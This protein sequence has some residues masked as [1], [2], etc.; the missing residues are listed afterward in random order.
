MTTLL[1]KIKAA[2]PKFFSA[3]NR[4]FMEDICF[5]GRR[6]KKGNAFLIEKTY[7]FS[8]MLGEPR[9]ISFR[10]HTV[11]TETFKIEH[12]L[13]TAYPTFQDAKDYIEFY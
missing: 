7:M 9:K 12:L 10:V 11:N 13:E 6:N 4:R 8:S 2:Q 1:D 3:G 5:Y